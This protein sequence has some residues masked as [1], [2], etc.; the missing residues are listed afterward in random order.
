VPVYRDHTK[1]DFWQTSKF[2]EMRKIAENGRIREWPAAPQPWLPDV[3]Q[4]TFALSDMLNKVLNENM[5]IEDAQGWAQ[6]EMMKS[7]TKLVKP[8]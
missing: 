6:E 1:T 8:A 2:A 4:A 5:N 3:Q 7:Y